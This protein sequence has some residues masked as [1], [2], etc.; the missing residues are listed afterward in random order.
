MAE[1]IKISVQMV[2][3]DDCDGDLRFSEKKYHHHLTN[4]D[5]DDAETECGPEE[6]KNYRDAETLDSEDGDIAT[7]EYTELPE[8]GGYPEKGSCD[9]LTEDVC[10]DLSDETDWFSIMKG[11]QLGELCIKDFDNIVFDSVDDAEKFYSYYAF[12]L[13]FSKKRLRIESEEIDGVKT[14]TR[15]AW[16]CS[17]EGKCVPKR[18]ANEKVLGSYDVNACGEEENEGSDEDMNEKTQGPRLVKCKKTKKTVGRDIKYSRTGCGAY[19]AI[20]LLRGKGKYQVSRFST[21]HNHGLADIFERHFLRSNRKVTMQDILEVEALGDANV[22]KSAAFSYL[23]DQSGGEAFVGFMKKDLYNKMAQHRRSKTQYGDAEAAMNWLRVRGS[24]E[25]KFY[26]RYIRDSKKRLAGLFWRDTH[27]LLDYELYGDVVVID[28]TYKTNVYG[29]PLVLFVGANNHR[30]TVVFACA[31][32]CNEKEP[33]YNW[34]FEKFLDCMNN[35]K[36]KSVVTDGCDSMRL[37]IEKHIP[38]ANHRLCAWHIGRNVGQN[39][40]DSE[41]QKALGKLIYTSYSRGEWQ[42]EWDSMTKKHKLED[43]SWLQTLHGKRNKWAESFC[44]GQWYAGICTTQR[45][46]GM[47]RTAK[48]KLNKFTTLV[49]FI[50]RYQRCISRLRDRVLYDNFKSKNHIREY[51]THFLDME[52]FVFNTFTDDIYIVIRTQMDFEKKFYVTSRLPDWDFENLMVYVTQYGKVSRRWTVQYIAPSVSTGVEESYTCSC[53]LFES[54]GIPCPHIFC[55][56]KTEG[57]TEYPKSL[58]CERWKKSSGTRPV[59][60]TSFHCSTGFN[61][62]RYLMLAHA[63]K[64]ACFNFA[65]SDEGFEKGMTFLKKLQDESLKF[66]FPKRPR[67]MVQDNEN[68][69]RDPVVART[70]GTHWNSE[71]GNKNKEESGR[72]CSICQKTGHNKTTCPTVKVNEN[73]A[74]DP[75][76]IPLSQNTC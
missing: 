8:V 24:E 72:K 13:D 71:E 53:Q 47:N 36:P 49:N 35:M 46:E 19:M 2:E 7:H 51:A 1:E 40:K 11:K 10:P 23:A 52:H 45:C 70:K 18:K 38:E 54:D 59:D 76:D 20:R 60:M 21:K 62:A 32:V 25:E 31:L 42:R 15:R 9:A 6:L 48:L 66:R 5:F 65:N 61:A 29:M 55:V 30:A 28:A 69:V 22:C 34:V 26:C 64:K 37:A 17:K 67:L 43:N 39:I 27:S 44:R 50:P 73:A 4:A 3:E 56:L 58:I 68:V 57:V 74:K 63:A 16:A 75:A 33:M 14:I 41:V 12:M